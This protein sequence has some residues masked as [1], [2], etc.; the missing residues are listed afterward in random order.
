MRIEL[1]IGKQ[2]KDLRIFL[3]SFFKYKRQSIVKFIV[4]T[5]SPFSLLS[6]AD[7][8]RIGLSINRSQVDKSASGLGGINNKVNLK[9]IDKV[10]IKVKSDDGYKT[11]KPKEFWLSYSPRTNSTVFHS[12]IGLDFLNEQRLKLV[13]NIPNN[14]AYLE[15]V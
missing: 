15:S 7:A 2:G 8:K 3:L 1:Q 12:L 6:E 10:E 14:E 9:S 11:F 4:D 13:V 5:G